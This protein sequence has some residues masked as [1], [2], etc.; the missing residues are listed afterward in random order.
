MRFGAGSEEDPDNND[1]EVDE[2]DEEKDEGK[3]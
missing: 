1:T 3:N 2:P